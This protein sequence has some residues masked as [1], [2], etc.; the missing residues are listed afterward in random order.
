MLKKQKLTKFLFGL[1]VFFKALPSSMAAGTEGLNDEQ[2]DSFTEGRSFFHIPWVAA[3][4]STTAR[5]GLGPLFSSNTC[6]SCHISSKPKDPLITDKFV[7]SLYAVKLSQFKEHLKRRAEQITIPDPVY[8][9]QLSSKSIS[10]VPLEG[11]VSLAKRIYKTLESGSSSISLYNWEIVTHHLGYGPISEDTGVSIRITPTLIGIGYVESLD[12]E[13]IEQIAKEQKANNPSMA[14][15]VNRVFNPL[16][17][18]MEVGKF[19]WK[20]SQASV[21]TQ[22]GDAA[23]N[24]MGLTNAVSNQESCTKFQVECL[25]APRGRRLKYE[26]HL[27]DYDLPTHR[28]ESIAFYVK[29]I[30][31][32]PKKDL[33]EEPIRGREIFD[34]LQCS[35]CHKPELKTAQGE[36]FKPFSD[37]LLHDMGDGLN[38]RRPEF[39]ATISEWRTAP[40]WR[41]YLKA[42]L[43]LGYLHD[44]RAQTLEE[45]I[46]W[47]GGQASASRDAFLK[48]SKEDR[49]ALL[50]FLN[51]L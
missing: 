36:V 43:G 51:S 20:A 25:N 21:V 7:N 5:D 34:G 37:Y 10:S 48:L 39:E 8:G 26:M 4:S 1:V 40:L 18:N 31:L 27:P 30:P 19:G 47:H 12:G 42:E 49:E 17:K 45:A 14:G 38:D 6:A 24:D 3:P 44:G 35:F 32:P 28:L 46:G 16:T 22:T 15:R 50:I 2:I 9:H 23:L 11:R 33:K 41:N 29:K 13:Y